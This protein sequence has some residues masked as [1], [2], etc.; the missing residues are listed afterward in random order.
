MWP[1]YLYLNE[2]SLLPMYFLVV[3]GVVSIVAS[4]FLISSW[5]WA[6]L[7]LLTVATFCC[8]F[9]ILIP[10]VGSEYLGVVNGGL[11]HITFSARKAFADH[12]WQLLL[13]FSG[14]FESMSI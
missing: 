8:G 3:S 7:W 12:L 2:S 11:Y 6:G 4:F 1:W 14:W 5:D 13:M 10:S 9:H